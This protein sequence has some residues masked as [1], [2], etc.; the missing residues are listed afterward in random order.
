MEE[1]AE[2]NAVYKRMESVFAERGDEITQ[3]A[4]G[5]YFEI[6]QTA[7][8]KWMSSGVPLPRV[9]KFCTDYGIC[10]NWLLAEIEPKYPP[11]QGLQQLIGMVEAEP[12]KLPA[13]LDYA[14]YK[15][16]GEDNH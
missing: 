11:G 8:R 2:I 4:I 16:S 15:T 3:T 14:E 5:K 10:P 1:G 9:L 7:V 12:D 6:D 13:I